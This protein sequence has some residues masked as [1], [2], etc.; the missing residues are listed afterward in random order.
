MSRTIR[1]SLQQVIIRQPAAALALVVFLAAAASGCGQ[2]NTAE[3]AVTAVQPT[4]I[5]A[6]AAPP[7]APA[8]A[9]AT[10]DT[11]TPVPATT[12][13]TEAATAA[14]PEPTAAATSAAQPES[15]AAG[16]TVVNVAADDVLNVREGA[17]VSHEIVGTIPPGGQQVQV[18]GTAVEVAGS[19]WAPVQYGSVS[20]WVNAAYLAQQVGTVDAAVAQQASA[21][22]QALADADMAALAAYVHPERGVRF[23]PYA[24]VQ[25][26]D[27]VFTAEQAAGLMA[28]PTVYHWGFF[29]GSGAPIEMTFA[30]YYGRFVY[31][32]AFV[33]PDAVG[34]DVALGAGNT[35]NN[36]TAFYPDAVFVEYYLD[37]SNPDFGGMDW[38]SLRL[39]FAPSSGGW[40]LVG[41]VHAEWTV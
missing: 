17:G 24:F 13:P 21:V 25:E 28:D 41:I 34:Y 3:T 9:G 12:V 4:S 2:G 15:A 6:T 1:F 38:R 11:A 27:R 36:L 37:G 29:D 31:D 22:L 8:A 18:T 10:G 16:Y 19:A 39:V 20:G 14:P 26:D 33:Q 23:S 35:L 32:V 5:L 7:T 40:A 30:D